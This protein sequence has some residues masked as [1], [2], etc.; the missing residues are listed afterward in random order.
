MSLRYARMAITPI[1][2]THA[3]RT[4]TTD[5]SGSRA[6]SLSAPVRGHMA[7]TVTGTT[8]PVV[9]SITRTVADMAPTWR[10][11]AHRP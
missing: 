6:E 11:D 4:A 7:I 5:Q 8:T 3:F 1:I 10:M 9:V 2:H